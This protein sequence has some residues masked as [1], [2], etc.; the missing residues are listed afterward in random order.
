MV[1]DQFE[2]NVNKS[3]AKVTTCRCTLAEH[4]SVIISVVCFVKG[5]IY[6]SLSQNG[7]DTLFLIAELNKP[8]PQAPI[9][10]V[11]TLTA[12]GQPGADGG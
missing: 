2:I 6:F 10:C 7:K 5:H 11:N 9:I 3:T 8:L 1:I 12:A 4:N